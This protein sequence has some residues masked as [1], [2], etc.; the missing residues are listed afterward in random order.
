MTYS[1]FSQRVVFDS[2][3][4]ESD[5]KVVVRIRFKLRDDGRVIETFDATMDRTFNGSAMHDAFVLGTPEPLSWDNL[6]RNVKRML[7]NHILANYRIEN[8]PDFTDLELDTLL[9]SSD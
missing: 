5:N 2:E 8:V 6:V 7:F 1:E 3:V 9:P 4:V